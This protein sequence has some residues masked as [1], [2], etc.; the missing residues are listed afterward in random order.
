MGMLL[1][2][3]EGYGKN[4][5]KSSDVNPAVKAEE[6]KSD[7]KKKSDKKATEEK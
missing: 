1:R 5:T 6:K 4:I 7:S 2:R 3:H